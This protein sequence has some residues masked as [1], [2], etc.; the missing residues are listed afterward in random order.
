MS[1][2]LRKNKSWSTYSLSPAVEKTRSAETLVPGIHKHCLASLARG[3]YSCWCSFH[4]SSG[5]SD[6]GKGAALLNSFTSSAAQSKADFSGSTSACLLVSPKVSPSNSW[7]AQDTLLFAG[8]GP[9]KSPSP[10]FWPSSATLFFSHQ[11]KAEQL[12]LL[13]AV[14]EALDHVISTIPS[15]WYVRY[16]FVCGAPAASVF[17]PKHEVLWHFCGKIRSHAALVQVA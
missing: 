2:F 4:H 6:R 8:G 11:G 14:K 16:Q 17:A 15:S 7:S 10:S 9:W 5:L 13:A 12:W 1:R 3:G